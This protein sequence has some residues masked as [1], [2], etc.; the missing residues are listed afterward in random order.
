MDSIRSEAPILRKD[1]TGFDQPIV[2]I[3]G[4]GKPAALVAKPTKKE[5]FFFCKF[6]H[7]VFRASHG[8]DAQICLDWLSTPELK[9]VRE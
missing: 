5:A 1:I 7:P 3:P 4:D 9:I 2:F 6:R 8:A